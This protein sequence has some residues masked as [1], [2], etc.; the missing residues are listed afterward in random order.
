MTNLISAY[1]TYRD[2]LVAAGLLIDSGVPGL[3]GRN[4]T[5]ESIVSGLNALVD[6]AAKPDNPEHFSFP[7]LLSRR[8]YE[9]SDHLRSFPDLMGAVHS[10]RGGD[11]EHRAL[12]ARHEDGEDWA[13]DLTST[14][15]M[16]CPAAC[17]PLYPML[18]GHGL[19][20][21]GR[22]F[23]VVGYCFR[24]EPSVDPARMQLF[25]MHEI[26]FVGEPDDALAFRNRWIDR[27]LDLLGGL[28]LDVRAEVANDP[29][30]GRAGKMLKAN[31]VEAH[32]KYEIVTPI[33]S[34]QDQTAIASC[35]SHVDHLTVPFALRL[36]D[37][38]VAH[39]ACVGFGL[40]RVTLALLKQHGL[41]VQAW[42]NSVRTALH[43]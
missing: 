15:L 19:P 40:E 41:H 22:C 34:A 17:Y 29:F 26:V 2:E 42:P 31:Q 9:L 11:V 32:L 14:N 27:C 12:I 35:N 30:F 28:G 37:G 43:L 39:S 38:G 10:F 1:E 18:H 33:C 3:F 13:A 25:R 24:H 36:S 4:S 7:P 20:P 23:D 6:D 21:G 8:N 5:F 16:L